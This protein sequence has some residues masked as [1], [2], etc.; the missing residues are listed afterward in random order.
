MREITL[1]WLIAFLTLAFTIQ[2]ASA[3][4]LM[5][6]YVDDDASADF[7]NIQ[8][9]INAASPG[10][11]IQVAPGTYWENVVINKQLKLLGDDPNTTIIDGGGNSHT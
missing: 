5:T 3:A 1:L 2:S 10:D 6:W 11:A 9:A 8:N 7:D 4:E